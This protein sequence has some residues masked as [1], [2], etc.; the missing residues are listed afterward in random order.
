MHITT[1]GLS[2][3][4]SIISRIFKEYLERNEANQIIMIVPEIAVSTGSQ[5]ALSGSKLVMGKLANITPFDDQFREM[6][7]KQLQRIMRNKEK[8]NLKGLTLKECDAIVQSKNMRKITKKELEELLTRQRY[9]AETIK[10]VKKLF[11]NHKL[12]HTYPITIDMIKATGL[13]VEELSD[14]LL[15]DAFDEL[16]EV[17]MI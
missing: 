10:N 12:Y 6:G 1:G 2:S 14:Q 8:Y 9:D 11:L 13:K 15:L 3:E 16:Y 5:L 17:C 4:C 7:V